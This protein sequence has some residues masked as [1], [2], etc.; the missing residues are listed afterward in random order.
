MAVPMSVNMALFLVRREPTRTGNAF[1]ALIAILGSF[2]ISLMPQ[3]HQTTAASAA[4]QVVGLM[5]WLWALTTLGRSFGIAP[6]DRGLKTSGPYRL[7]RHPVYV[8]ELIV[9]AGVVVANPTWL[10]AGTLALWW[11]LQCWRMVREERVISGYEGYR[12]ATR[13][14]VLPGVW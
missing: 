8:G 2:S 7:V 12:A 6:A 1:D 13:W 5:F 14:R 9:S 3:A 11:L 4:V 10:A